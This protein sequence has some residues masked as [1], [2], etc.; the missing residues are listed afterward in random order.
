MVAWL[1]TLMLGHQS[2]ILSTAL[3]LLVTSG[4]LTFHRF[5]Q[6][7]Q[8]CVRSRQATQ[9]EES[10]RIAVEG[11][12]KL[13]PAKHMQSSCRNQDLYRYRLEQY[14]FC[15]LKNGSIISLVQ[16][17]AEVA[18]VGQFHLRTNALSSIC[19]SDRLL[20]VLR[21]FA[22]VDVQTLSTLATLRQEHSANTP[23]LNLNS[24]FGRLLDPLGRIRESKSPIFK[25]RA[26]GD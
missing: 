24:I 14:R 21:H 3:P 25:A 6:A 2:Q 15:R 23:F 1:K 4:C 18:S 12:D 20:D 7:L 22:I 13:L 9:P 8:E 10:L 16:T 5:V 19:S 17:I 11:L 26:T